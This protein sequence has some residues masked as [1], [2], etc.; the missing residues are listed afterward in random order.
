MQRPL[1]LIFILF[2]L[3]GK[4]HISPA[5]SNTSHSPISRFG[6]GQFT[7]I[8]LARNESMAGC[9]IASPSGDHPNFLNPALLTFNE[10]VNLN[11]DLRYAFQSIKVSDSYSYSSGS[12]GPSFISM[13]VP[14]SKRVSVAG[15]IRPFSMRNFSYTEIVQSGS[16]SIGLKT[17][18]TG[19]TTQF[20]M[21]G[22]YR[23]HKNIDIG[24]EASYIFGTI[25]DSVIFGVLPET[26]NYTFINIQKRKVSQFVLKPGIH[27]NLP[28]PGKEDVFMGLGATADIGDALSFRKYNTFTVLGAATQI[29]TLEYDQKS[30]IR[31]PVGYH[32]GLS[33]YKP[34]NWSVSAE[35]DYTKAAGISNEGLNFTYA[36]ALT[37]R[38]GFE[39]SPGTKKSTRYVNIMTFRGGLMYQQLPY[40]MGGD[41]VTDR[42]ISIGASFPIIRKEA[43][44]SRPL[45]NLGVSYGRRGLKN[46][47]LGMENYF[48]VNLSFTLND[49]LWFNRY[50][51]D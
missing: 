42:R 28:F 47:Y 16:D 44:F 37:Y 1:A 30:S 24:M 13:V 8:G 7:G 35:V 15:G 9:G 34:L 51:I 48:Q 38:A 49:F 41:F 50:K 5:Q 14:L 20:F 21:A 31:R 19:G 43:K 6:I 39:F 11:F 10:K 12:G 23:I 36:D 4:S 25:Q 2:V 18:G 26:S 40:K 22:G 3:V 33:L 27:L 32:F 45:I 46:S 29:D 17:R